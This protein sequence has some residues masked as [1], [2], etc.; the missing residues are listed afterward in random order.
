MRRRYKAIISD[1][2]KS[3]RRRRGNTQK[4]VADLFGVDRST[5]CYYELGKIKPDIATIMKLS[6][7]FGVHY[8]GI[9]ESEYNSEKYANKN[10]KAGDVSADISRFSDLD[11]EEKCLLFAFR[12]ASESSRREMIEFALSKIKDKK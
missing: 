1:T 4:E 12:L 3:I 6:N 10:L 8:T 7:I 9:L 5:Y 11:N 2:I